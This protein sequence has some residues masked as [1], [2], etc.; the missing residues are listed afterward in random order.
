M[1]MIQDPIVFDL[2]LEGFTVQGDSLSSRK[3]VNADLYR[4]WGRLFSPRGNPE[5]QISISINWAPFFAVSLIQKKNFC[6]AKKYL[7]SEAWKLMQQEEREQTSLKFSLPYDCPNAEVDC[8]CKQLNM[9][10][11]AVPRTLEHSALQ[12]IPHSTYVLL[13]KKEKRKTSGYG[14]HRTKKKLE[15]KI[16]KHWF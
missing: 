7:N 16:S 4:L 12:Q 6:L 13:P 1:V 3:D 14:R 2:V 11:M 15:T 9:Q 10:I 5:H 8:P